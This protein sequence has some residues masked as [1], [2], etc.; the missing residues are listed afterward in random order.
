[1][2]IYK[3]NDLCEGIRGNC[4]FQKKDLQKDFEINSFVGLHYGK[5]YKEDKI[6]SSYPYYVDK[7]FFKANQ[8]VEKNDTVLISTSETLED[9]GHSYIYNRDSVGL[10]GGEQILLKAKESVIDKQYLYYLSKGLKEQFRRYATGM[11]VYRFKIQDF[12]FIKVDVPA[13]ETQKKIIEIIKPLEDSIM[14]IKNQINETKKLLINEYN[15]LDTSRNFLQDYIKNHTRKYSGQTK[16]LATNAIGEFSI[17]SHKAQDISNQK[18]SRAN[19]TP[20]NN[21]IIVSKLDGENKMM[22]IDDAFKYVV[23]TGFFNFS[24]NHLDHLVGFLLSNDFKKQKSMLSTGTTMVGLNNSGLKRIKI[25]SPINKNNTLTN[26]L[27]RLILTEIKLSKQKDK[28]IN[29][30]IK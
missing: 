24:T 7:I 22:Y 17:D 13:L 27:N 25:S 3:L 1:M 29:L 14:N 6:N 10:L 19:L 9:L 15:L 23:S 2:A 18:P 12:K 28:I 21:S 4:S 5:T 26:H 11:K 30:L 20:E 8:I 16:Y